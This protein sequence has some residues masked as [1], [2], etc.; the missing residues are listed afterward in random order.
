MFLPRMTWGNWLFWGILSF[1][2]V[3]FLW[4][5]WLELYIPLWIG[6]VIG[7]VV[8]LALLVYGPREL[9]EAEEGEE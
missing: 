5:G 1:V 4:L 7:L 8:F 6:A 2:G 9:E 3:N